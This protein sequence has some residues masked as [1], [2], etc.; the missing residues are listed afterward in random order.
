MTVFPALVVPQVP[1][2]LA[3]PKK[4]ASLLLGRW[5]FNCFGQTFDIP[6]L[7]GRRLSCSM[8]FAWPGHSSLL[9]FGSWS[10]GNRLHFILWSAL[11]NFISLLWRLSRA[12][13]SKRRF[14]DMVSPL[15]MQGDWSH[16]AIIVA[17]ALEA[18]P[19]ALFIKLKCSTRSPDLFS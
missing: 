19:F 8:F 9:S 6:C 17:L 4:M 13:A 3:D 18:G 5:V 1:E 14:Q 16:L 15:A 2:K 11:N 7:T 12:L 10:I